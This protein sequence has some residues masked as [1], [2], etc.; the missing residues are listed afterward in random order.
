MVRLLSIPSPSQ[1]SPTCNASFL[2]VLQFQNVSVVHIG[3]KGN[4]CNN[5]RILKILFSSCE[6]GSTYK[7]HD[8]D[9]VNDL[10]I[11]ELTV[12]Q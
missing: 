8:K 10:H 9:T 11:D 2:Q 6:Q 5:A 1:H 12:I 7:I 4:H 3:N